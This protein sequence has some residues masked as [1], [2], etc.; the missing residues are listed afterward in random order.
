MVRNQRLRG[1]SGRQDSSSGVEECPI[2]V[3]QLGPVDQCG[4]S[5]NSFGRLATLDDG[6]TSCRPAKPVATDSTAIWSSP[7]ESP[8]GWKGVEV[9][10]HPAPSRFLRIESLFEA[11]LVSHCFCSFQCLHGKNQR[12]ELLK[13]PEF[14][15]VKTDRGSLQ[16]GVLLCLLNQPNHTF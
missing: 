14:G 10:A 7:P 13:I 9:H 4:C 15:E 5:E 12:I 6:S 8:A 11:S 16:V 3:P 1:F 2:R